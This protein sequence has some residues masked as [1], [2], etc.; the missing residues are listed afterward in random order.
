MFAEV[1]ALQFIASFFSNEL[2]YI[3]TIA[4]SREARLNAQGALDFIFADEVSNDEGIIDEEKEFES[5]FQSEFKDEL[6]DVNGKLEISGLLPAPR[7]SGRV[8][9]KKAFDKVDH[10]ILLK[11]LSHYGIRGIANEWFKS[12]L[13]NRMQYGSIDGISSN[14]VKVNF[15]VPQGTWSSAFPFKHK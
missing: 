4:A 10:E 13:T 1:V 2:L 11:K 6:D 12:Y 3:E 7:V 14:L 5:S 9:S 8:N 15:G